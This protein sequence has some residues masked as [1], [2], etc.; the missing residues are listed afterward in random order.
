MDPQERLAALRAIPEAEM[1]PRS[2]EDRWSSDEQAIAE[3]L[4]QVEPFD[5]GISAEQAAHEPA[6]LEERAN[7]RPV[8]PVV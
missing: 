5:P 6:V 4:I 7:D 8:P 1:V 3:G 2:I